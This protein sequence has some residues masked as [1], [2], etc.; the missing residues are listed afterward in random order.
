MK[1]TPLQQLKEKAFK[2]PA[3]KEAYDLDT[4]DIKDVEVTKISYPD[5]P[6]DN[7]IR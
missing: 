7:R 4:L 2:D 6:Q 1:K 3:V 5:K